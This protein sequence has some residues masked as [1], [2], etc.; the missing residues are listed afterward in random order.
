[1][2]EEQLWEVCPA[3]NKPKDKRLEKL[4]KYLPKLP[5]TFYVLGGCGSGKSSFLWSILS[6]GYITGK[7]KKSVFDECIFYLGTLDSKSAFEKLPI[8]NLLILDEFDPVMFEAYQ[9]DL[10]THQ[11]EK[12]SE[13]KAPLNT[14]LVFDDFVN[15]GLMKKARQN[16]SPPIE[17]LALTSRHES[18]CSIFFCSQVYRNSGFSQPSVRNNITTFVVYRMSR[19]ELEKICEELCEM[20]DPDELLE[21]FDKAFARDS[22][23]FLVLDRRR[24]IG[25]DRWTEKLSKPLPPSK[26]FLEMEALRKVGKL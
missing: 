11:M 12:L 18:N 14:L 19:V 13:G 21:H 25:T 20:Y 3:E 8:E 17:K 9:N 6:N 10:K 22:Y 7:K 16:T 2:E 4:P 15:G 5:A 23:N 26:K 1:M 24:P